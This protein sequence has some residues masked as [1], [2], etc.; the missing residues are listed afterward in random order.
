[1]TDSTARRPAGFDCAFRPSSY[2]DD[3]DPATIIVSSILGQ[4]RRKDVLERLAS[5]D[6]DP[7]VLGE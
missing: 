6:F 5:K 4:E 1:M 2:F 7:R 3:L